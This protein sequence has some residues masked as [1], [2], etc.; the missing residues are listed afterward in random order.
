MGF[1]PTPILILPST[2]NKTPVILAA[3]LLPM[4]PV[5]TRVCHQC[6]F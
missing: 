2:T 1:P 4:A 6:I 3:S 5:S